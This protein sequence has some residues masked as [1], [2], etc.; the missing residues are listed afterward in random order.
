MPYQ[1]LVSPENNK[2]NLR[3]LFGAMS[4]LTRNRASLNSQIPVTLSSN[5]F[6]AHFDCNITN[7]K[8]LIQS[9]TWA[10]HGIQTPDSAVSDKINNK[11]FNK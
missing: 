10:A 2:T 1:A 7:I 3:F 5:D 4:H 9:V 6:I 8:K 11:V